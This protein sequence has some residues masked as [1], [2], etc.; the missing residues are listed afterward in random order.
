MGVLS[1]LKK[2]A[3]GIVSKPTDW[4]NYADLGI[5]TVTGGQVDT[6]GVN[7]P[8]TGKSVGGI[9]D[10]LMGKK[11]AD[12]NPD[13]IADQ[14]RATQSQGIGELNAALDSTSGEALV[15]QQA[16]LAKKGVL[17]GAQDARRNAQRSM[18]QHGILNSSLGLAANRAIDKDVSSQTNAINA[19]L[20]GQIRQQ[21]LQD[22]QT[23]I[24]V[25]GVNQNGMN[26]NTIEG[27]RSGGILGYASQLAPMAGSIGQLMSGSAALSREKRLG[28]Q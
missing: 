28:G 1:R 24:D 19:A 23:R 15:N 14:I 16:A 9:E 17:A 20:P 26:F 18:A 7:N 8:L 25:G 6:R 4:R 5:Q 12:I 13:A 3:K 10:L 2:T 22:A 11:A 27:A 21:K